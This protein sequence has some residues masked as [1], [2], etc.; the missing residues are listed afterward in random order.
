[1][2]YSKPELHAAEAALNAIRGIKPDMGFD[3]D[4]LVSVAPAY[5]VDE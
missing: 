2:T 4:S 5:E 1:M 3:G